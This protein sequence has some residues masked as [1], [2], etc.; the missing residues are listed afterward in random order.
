MKID[1][2][3]LDKMIKLIGNEN[4][5]FIID[6]LNKNNGMYYT[7]ML[8]LFSR[9]EYHKSES[10]RFSHYLRG[11]VNVGA[12]RCDSMTKL[13][14]LTRVGVHLAETVNHFKTQALVYD[15]S[16][17]GEDGKPK[18]VVKIVGRKLKMVKVSKGEGK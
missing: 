12:I 18:H 13:Y 6:T 5:R 8:K 1:E 10:G 15:M 16:N 9:K 11:L 7:D 14:Y 3:K 2:N 4:S 17:L